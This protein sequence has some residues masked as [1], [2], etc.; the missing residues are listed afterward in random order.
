MTLIAIDLDGTLEDSRNDMVSAARKL[1]AQL[2][3]PA[4]ADAELRPFV[5]GGMEALYR[6]CFD[7]YL[8]ASDPA[9]QAQ[10]YAVV[11]EAY[12][13]EYLANVAIET[14]LYDGIAAALGE[15]AQLGA[16]AC[17]TN[18]PERISRK[19]LDELGVG[20]LFATVVGGDTCAQAKPHPMMLAAAVERARVDTRTAKVFMIGD[21]EA[22]M[23]LARAFGARGIWCAWGYVSALKEPVELKAEHPRELAAL[24]ARFA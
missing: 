7:D 20:A 4:R 16:L 5:N 1:R 15:L 23:Q 10:R 21:T 19:L 14:R 22:D 13:A 3:L 24:V 6:A 12:E 2:G 9:T 8:V 18:K 11:R 17:V